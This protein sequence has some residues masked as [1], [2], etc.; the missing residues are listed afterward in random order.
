MDFQNNFLEGTV[1]ESL[2]DLS[3]LSIFSVN[4]NTKFGGTISTKIGQMLELTKF[5][6]GNTKLAGTIPDEIYLLPKMADMLFVNAR[7]SGPLKQDI[8]RLNATLR[9]L[10]LNSNSF[11]GPLPTALDVLTGLENLMVM[12]NSFTGSISD[13]VCKERGLGFMKIS[14]LQAD[15]NIECIC[16]DNCPI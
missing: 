2:Y 14:R 7:M 3:T 16:N 4:N 15:C 1:P 10:N 13:E 11:T 6:A 12:D 9:V 5:E 8:F